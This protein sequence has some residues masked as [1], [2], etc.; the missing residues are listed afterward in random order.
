LK[1]GDLIRLRGPRKQNRGSLGIIT[2]VSRVPLGELCVII[3]DGIERQYWASSLEI[4]QPADETFV[5]NDCK[6]EREV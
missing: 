3:I 4:V 1:P 2:E 5:S 6:V